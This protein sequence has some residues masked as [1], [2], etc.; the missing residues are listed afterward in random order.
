MNSIWPCFFKSLNS[1]IF[2]SEIVSVLFLILFIIP[3]F[4]VAIPK[5][6]SIELYVFP[7]PGGP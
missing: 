4:L 3:S 1:L 7:V 2:S 6:Y 5:E